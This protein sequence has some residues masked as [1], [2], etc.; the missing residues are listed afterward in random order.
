MGK[1]HLTAPK[2][3][4]ESALG[5]PVRRGRPPKR[6]K[7]ED[8]QPLEQGCRKSPVTVHW[9]ERVVACVERVSWQ[10]R[11]FLDPQQCPLSARSVPAQCP[12]SAR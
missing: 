11:V 1:L 7:Q 6:R 8:A 5:E 10:D 3:E 4:L 12:L 9:A 2:P